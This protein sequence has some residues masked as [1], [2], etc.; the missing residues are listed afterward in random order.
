MQLWEE[1]AYIMEEAR[2]EGLALGRTEGITLGRTEG[3]A[4]G[5]TE[6]IALGRTEGI[7][8]GRA[9]GRAEGR[10]EGIT[11]FIL[12]NLE[13][14]KNAEIIIDKLVKRFSLSKE[15]AYQYYEKCKQG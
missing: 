7:A 13:D 3:I 10:S 4:L 15:D 9:E 2:A 6:G 12:D 14:G 11:A 5:R 1:K 8:L